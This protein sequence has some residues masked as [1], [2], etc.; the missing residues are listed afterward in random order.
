MAKNGKSPTL[1]V[2]QLSGGNDFMNTV[3]PYS[4]GLY[5]DN[6]KTIGVPEESVL[7]INDAVGFN[8]NAAPLKELYDLGRMAIIQGVG[9]AN[10]SRSHFRSMD[11][12]HTCDPDKIATEG[13]LGKVVRRLDPEKSNPLTAVSIG[14]GLPR[15]LSAQEVPVTSVADLDNYGL[16]SGFSAEQQRA[17]ALDLFKR[18]YTPAIGT[19]A[20]TDYLARTGIDV[21]RGA[22]MLK[23]APAMYSSN[24]EYADNPIAKSLRDVA[25]V[26]LAD[27]GTRIFYTQHGGYDTHANEAPTH[28]KLL[29]D[30]SRAIAD[31]YRDLEEHDAADNVVIL[32]FTEFGR[33]VQDNGS[34]TDHGAGGGAYLIGNH[35]RGGLYSEY[36]SLEPGKLENGDLRHTY[37]FRGLYSTLLEQWLDIEPTQIVGGK[38][39]QLPMIAV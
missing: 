1:V 20:V 21:L 17:D 31:F 37:D 34:G 14:R 19:A 18:I 25:R 26:H 15:A 36:P 16:M 6:R 9:Y 27:L 12:W 28:P 4:N 10:S 38:F 8:P 30:L 22:E 33:R 24:V 13:W 35:V 39:E 5:Y 32:V 7:R 29:T 3:I 11:I 2:V 23:K